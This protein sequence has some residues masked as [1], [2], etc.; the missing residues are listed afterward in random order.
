MASSILDFSALCSLKGQCCHD[1]LLL[2]NNANLH[3]KVPQT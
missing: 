1:S 2:V 3:V